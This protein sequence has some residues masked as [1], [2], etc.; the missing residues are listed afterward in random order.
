MLSFS[1][2]K[3]LIENNKIDFTQKKNQAL[4]V[5]YMSKEN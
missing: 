2:I 4:L 5:E 1:K 3:Y